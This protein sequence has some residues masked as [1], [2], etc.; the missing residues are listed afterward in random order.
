[1][2]VSFPIKRYSGRFLLNDILFHDEIVHET[3]LN[4]PDRSGSSNRGS[5]GLSSNE[6]Q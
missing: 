2:R 1:M 5:I 3:G 6:S 4:V